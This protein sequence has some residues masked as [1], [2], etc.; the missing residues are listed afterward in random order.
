MGWSNKPET[1]GLK[2]K[3]R[4]LRVEPTGHLC[5]GQVVR[6]NWRCVTDD[7]VRLND[8]QFHDVA[9]TKSG[10]E[11]TL[12]VDGALTKQEHIAWLATCNATI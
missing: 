2:W 11:I 10:T 1:D 6:S 12:Y 4:E 3:A 7:E 5:Y 8:G 9:V